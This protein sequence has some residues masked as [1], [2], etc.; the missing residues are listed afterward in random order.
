MKE[1]HE[2]KIKNIDSSR[3]ILISGLMVAVAVLLHG[4]IVAK[5]G[6]NTTK[7]GLVDKSLVS[8]IMSLDTSHRYFDESQ[9]TEEVVFV[10]YSDTECP[11]CKNF[12]QTMHD[13]VLEGNGKYAW[14]YKHF[15]LSI[16]PKAQKQAEAIE[17]VREISG[18]QTAIK[19]MDVMF[20]ITESNNKLPDEALY[21]ISDA[22]KIKTSKLKE[23]I[24]SN[25]YA[26]KVARDTQEGIDKG[27]QGTPHT[28]VNKM[29]DGSYKEIGVING[30]QPREMIDALLAQ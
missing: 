4:V 7:T 29:V 15:P 30:A 5:L 16:H 25:K 14:V 18:D 13:L 12:H 27:V 8:K 22:M 20:A 6:G 19:Y 9:A 24:D 21:E 1:I 3:A 10:E 26:E 17:C 2:N 28:I 11:F 23:C